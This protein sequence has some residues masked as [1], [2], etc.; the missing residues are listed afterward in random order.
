MFR[1]TQPGG[2]Y[3]ITAAAGSL[4]ATATVYV[5]SAPQSLTAT[6][7]NAQVTLAWNKPAGTV[8]S[9][10]VT[11][12]TAPGAENTTVTGLTSTTTTVTGLTNGQAYYFVV[13]TTN[14][15]GTS[16][17]SGEVSATPSASAAPVTTALTP[18]ADS[19]VW[20]GSY[21]GQNKGVVAFL[22]V[23]NTGSP[24]ASGDR[25]AYLKFDL[26]GMTQAPTSAKLALMVDGSSHPTTGA[27]TVQIFS[28]TDTSWTELGV[29]WNNAPGLNTSS[30]TSTGTL[31]SSQSVSLKSGTP[32]T[33][34]LTS[35]VSSHLGQVVTLQLFNPNA[36][37][38]ISAFISREGTT[39]K[40][41]LT[42]TY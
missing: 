1:A 41:T 24:A 17:N 33:Y 6:P 34:D 8:T 36:D 26:T 3:V 11:Y 42:L 37:S 30:F 15:A 2:P 39:G 35:F 12:G 13:S 21:A 32:L 23:A 4:N 27:A 22:T 16:L 38:A 5:P 19:Y 28:I 14:P 10:T 20:S 40:P 31:L 18:T 7:G 29:T 25:C 9:Y